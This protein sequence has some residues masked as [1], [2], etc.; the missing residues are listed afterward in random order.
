ME[1]ANLGYKAYNVVLTV[2]NRLLFVAVW[3]HD[4]FIIPKRVLCRELNEFSL[5]LVSK[6]AVGLV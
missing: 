1:H 5:F 4:L 2:L 6:Y 3:L